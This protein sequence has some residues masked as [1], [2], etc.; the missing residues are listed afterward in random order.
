MQNQ[1]IKSTVWNFGVM[2][3]TKFLHSLF[4]VQ[5][6]IVRI[7]TFSVFLAQTALI[8]S[9]L[10]LLSLIKIVLQ[11]TSVSMYKLINNM[12]PNA[13]NSLIVRNNATHHYNT[14]RNHFLRGSRPTC[15]PVVNSFTNRN[16]Q[17]WNAI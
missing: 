3:V 2:P 17:I 15:K 12:L 6:K 5:K 9:K 10:R 1:L 16:V 13:K 11:R 7:I 4:L 8:F 14:R